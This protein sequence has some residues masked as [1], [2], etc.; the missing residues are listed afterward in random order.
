MTYAAIMVNLTLGHSNTGALGAAVTVATHCGASLA[1]IAASRP[2]EIICGD[3]AVPA[4]LYEEDRKQGARQ[5]KLAEAEFHA[6]VAGLQTPTSWQ[7]TTTVIPLADHLSLHARAADLIVVGASSRDVPIDITRQVD[8]CDLIMG[9]GRPVLV[10]PSVQAPGRFRRILV[11]WNDSR[12]AR[13]AISDALP[14]L[15]D[16]SRTS[17]IQITSTDD[18]SAAKTGMEEVKRWLE[19]HRVHVDASVVPARGAN[20][21]QLRA[22]AHDV[23]ADLIVAGAYGYRRTREWV[24][25]GVTT[26][27]LA[28]DHCVL[29]SH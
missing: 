23:G 24:L 7:A 16:D 21:K 9:A 11:A 20:A 4:V 15:T 26:D 2:I 22:I 10:A 28:G 19:R 14:L 6:A 18:L 27:L 1:G 17:V 13:R 25:G 8:L 12:E 29:F 5:T 3:Y